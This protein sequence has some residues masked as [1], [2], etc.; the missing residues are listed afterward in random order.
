MLIQLHAASTPCI[1]MFRVLSLVDL[2]S[3][4]KRIRL[5][6]FEPETVSGF[7]VKPTGA[8]VKKQAPDRPTMHFLLCHAL[9]T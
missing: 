2:D 6:C 8:A 3:R 4:R 9:E 7:T 1:Q 5:L